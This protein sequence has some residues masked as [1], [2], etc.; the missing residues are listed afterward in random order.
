M[1]ELNP[2][3]GSQAAAKTYR[4]PIVALIGFLL[5]TPAILGQNKDY[6]IDAELMSTLSDSADARA[7]FFVLFQETAN[8]KAA[9][10]IANRLARA[11]FVVGALSEVA[12]RSQRQVRDYLTAQAVDFT[13]FWVRNSIYVRDG[14][15][16]LARAL[17]QRPEVAAL[18]LEEIFQLPEPQ[19]SGDGGTEAIAWGL[20]KI[21]AEQVW[22]TTRGAGIIVAN[23]DTGAQFDHPALVNQYLGNLGGGSFDHTNTWS[24]PANVC[25]VAGEPCDNHN[26][27]THTMGTMVGDDGATNQI[28]VAPE[29][30]WIA[31]KGCESGFCSGFALSSC[32]QWVLSQVPH[33]VNNSWG[34]GGGNSWYQSWVR[35]WVNAGIFPAFSIG[36]SGSNCNTAGSPG[37]Y[38]ESF[39]SGATDG[40]DNVASFS[41]RG[42][43][44]FGGII[45]PNVSAP[46]VSV[47]SSITGSSYANFSGTS[48]ASPHTAGAVALFWAARP[49]FQ[50]DVSQTAQILE[51][52]A[53]PLTSS[54]SCGGVSGAAVPNNTYGWGRLDA[55]AAVNWDG[56]PN[57]P[58]TVIIEVPSE[59][60]SKDFPCGQ[61][62]NFQAAA[63]DVEDGPLTHLIQ[64][65]DDGV[66]FGEQ[67][68]SVFR[69]FSCGDL[70]L[71]TITARVE[72]SRYASD[73]DTVDVTIFDPYAIAAPG[74]LQASVNGTEVAA[75]WTSNSDNET[76]FQPQYKK[77][78]KGRGNKNASWQD[79]TP[80]AAENATGQTFPLP[81]GKYDLRVFAFN[82]A[83]G[84]QSDPSNVVRVTTTGGG[85][86]PP[87]PSGPPAAPSSLTAKARGKAIQLAWSDNANNETNF[88]IERCT[89]SGCS[90]FT[91]LQTVGANATSY[92][93][94]SVT[95]K[96][97]YRHRV[98]A[99][100]GDGASG[101]SN[102][103][104]ETAR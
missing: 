33:V 16:G 101:Y 8:T 55:L 48:M 61:P 82:S 42:P 9:R 91:L 57:T 28:G 83:T 90:G 12:E 64:W 95:S 51:E 98:S 32:A 2:G 3:L 84:R 93:D 59:Q 6:K 76:G 100:N 30:R 20:S 47:R 68:G 75:T 49:E 62:V 5:F 74:N 103:A 79:V 56:V 66:G 88:E 43:S 7:P 41:S 44:A 52:T 15:L 21:R 73:T 11:R 92:K 19:P 25:P 53:V 102:E 27:G 63:E 50:G 80:A 4:V 94:S 67:A 85:G 18:V 54:Q 35:Q 77:V 1:V 87:P 23:I 86:D 99:I 58:P 17:A 14:T 60:D 104:E 31:C 36:N 24:D 96:T 70:G 89:G 40:S 29:A 65:F 38:P 78:V 97:T 37:D 34:G 26:H 13:P 10:G 69:T 81:E 71:H 39:G 72:D 45:K 22:A 46:G